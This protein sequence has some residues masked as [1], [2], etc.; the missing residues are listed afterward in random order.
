MKSLLIWK[1]KY[2]ENEKVV[3]D[4]NEIENNNFIGR[5]KKLIM[6]VID[7]TDFGNIN[8]KGLSLLELKKKS[9][10]CYGWIFKK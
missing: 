4:M 3:E 2:Y 8:K 5:I 1:E 9:F 10:R 6:K 7:N